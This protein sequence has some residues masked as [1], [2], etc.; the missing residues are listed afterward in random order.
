[1]QVEFVVSAFS[2]RD[3]PLQGVAEV[4]LAGRSNVGKSSLINRLAG[5]RRLAHTSA[6]PG[7]TRS[8]NFYRLDRSVYLVDLP[9]YG[10]T[11]AGKASARD[12]RRLIESYFRSREC[13][14]LAIHLVDS[15]VPP[16]A[17]DQRL[18]DWLEHLRIPRMIAATKADKLSGND[19]AVQSRRLSEA[20]GGQPVLFCSAVTGQGCG[21]IWKRIRQASARQLEEGMVKDRT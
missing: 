12:W 18:A 4:V 8:I 3:F 6:A 13:I 15:R 5:R 2:E 1:M 21:E 17:L 14:V 10:Y 7:K 11:A 19:L 16:T 9:G 20:F